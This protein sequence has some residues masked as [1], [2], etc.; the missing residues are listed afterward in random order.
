MDIFCFTF[1]VGSP[2]AKY[3]VMIAAPDEDAA[4]AR[5]FC[6]FSQHWASCYRL[7]NFQAQI[8]RYGYLPLHVN[9]DAS[10]RLGTKHD[11]IPPDIY[12]SSLAAAKPDLEAVADP[13]APQPESVKA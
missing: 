7:I 10:V 1:G 9:Y 13:V 5:M 12:E 2:L 8:A 4:R 3:Y 11:E 6:L